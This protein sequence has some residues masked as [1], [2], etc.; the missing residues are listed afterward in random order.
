MRVK[1]HSLPLKQRHRDEER[2]YYP[3][4]QLSQTI[5]R[6]MD[7]MASKKVWAQGRPGLK[8]N[9]KI[10]P[11]MMAY[12]LETHSNGSPSW[13]SGVRA[14][15]SQIPIPLSPGKQTVGGRGR[16]RDQTERMVSCLYTTLPSACPKPARLMGRQVSEAKPKHYWLGR[17][18]TLTNAFH[19][20]DS[21]N[22]PDTATGFGMLSIYSH[23]LADCVDGPS[24]RAKRAFRVLENVCMTEEASVSL[25]RFREEY[26]RRFGGRWLGY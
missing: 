24:Y 4:R 23:R 18:V 3:Y 11:R 2:A 19:Y 26:A 6:T 25:R 8:A 15:F 7:E 21:F 16:G 1:L 13:K 17:F 22:E 9:E 5:A 20:E 10:S 14:G 12:G